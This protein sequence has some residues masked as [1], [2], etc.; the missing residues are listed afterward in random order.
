MGVQAADD[1]CDSGVA[2]GSHRLWSVCA[3]DWICIAASLGDLFLDP[4]AGLRADELQP[5]LFGADT[6]HQW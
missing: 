6:D 3:G 1:E 5:G 2:A 4:D